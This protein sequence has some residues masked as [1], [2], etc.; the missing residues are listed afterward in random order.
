MPDT[1]EKIT[2]LAKDYK[3]PVKLLNKLKS[4]PEKFWLARGEEMSLELFH[5]MAQKVPAYKDWLKK[6]KIDPKKIKTIEDLKK[7]PTIDKDNYLRKYPLTDLCWDGKLSKGWHVYSSTSGSTGEPFYFPRSNFQ[8]QQYSVTAEMYLINNFHIDK[9]TTLYVDGF[10][11]GAWIGGLFTYQA[12]KNVAERGNYNLS[13]ITPGINKQEIIKAIR[14]LGPNY[15]QVI[16]GGY[17][18]FVKDVIDEGIAQGIKWSD[19]NLRIIFS[20]EAFSEKF[21]DYIA[22]RIDLENIYSLTLNHY[23]T[24]DQGTIA[25][26]T[27]LSVLI[28]R[29]A[30][31]QSEIF[32]EVFGQTIKVPTLAQ[33]LP[34]MFYFEEDKGKIICSTFSG[35]PLVRYDLKDNGGIFTL[36]EI[37]EKSKKFDIDLDDEIK[38]AKIKDTIMNLPFV[39]VYERADLSVC[40]SG[41]NVYPE[42]IKRIIVEP[43]FNAKLTGKFTMIIERD[44]KQ[45]PHLVIHFELKD[46]AKIDKA[47]EKDLKETI[48][49][50]LLSENSEYRDQYNYDKKRAIPNLKF[51]PQDDPHYFALKGKQKWV[52]K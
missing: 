5:L 11:M 29:L 2:S 27:P 35:I 34:E 24:V 22:E 6:K 50:T 33:Y 44:K 3:D 28:R 30:I 38:K 40:L 9:K 32:Q 48:L 16:L 47:Y 12:V 51:W 31:G 7:I 10:A 18:P 20:A 45:D 41:A 43:K 52:I 39:F 36:A 42:P 23:G 1:N 19:Y 13:I 15:E 49:K 26:E 8:D 14:N 46:K 37:K 4:K 25:H 17:P 21:R